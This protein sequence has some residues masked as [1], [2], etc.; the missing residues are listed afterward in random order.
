MILQESLN[1]AQQRAILA[2]LIARTETYG[3]DRIKADMIRA[4]CSPESVLILQDPKENRRTR[5][6]R[7]GLTCD[8]L[9]LV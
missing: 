4:F 6:I 7:K 2:F 1:R 8:P 5:E 9:D 3:Y